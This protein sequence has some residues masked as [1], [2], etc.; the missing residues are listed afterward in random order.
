MTS[1]AVEVSLALLWSLFRH[2]GVFHPSRCMNANKNRTSATLQANISNPDC[3]S[4]R[5]QLNPV[6]HMPSEEGNATLKYIKMRC[7]Y[8]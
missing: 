7:T 8:R 2:I 4:A 1:S 3:F 6:C 5:L